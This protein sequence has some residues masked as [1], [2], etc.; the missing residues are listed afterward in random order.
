MSLNE[1]KP[2]L[3]IN[4]SPR[5]EQS[6]TLVLSRALVAGY[7]AQTG[8]PVDELTVYE[9]NIAPCRGCLT[10]WI[11]TPGKCVIRDDMDRAHELM[12]EAGL[13]V[14]SFPLY[15]FGMPSQL[16]AFLD[17]MVPVMRFYDGGPTVLRPHY[18]FDDKHFVVVSTCGF[19]ESGEIYDPLRSHIRTLFEGRAD[20]IAVP[21]GE[22]IQEPTMRDILNKRLEEL[23]EAGRALALEGRIPA[24][25]AER[26]S[27]PLINTRAFE[28]ILKAKSNAIEHT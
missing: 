16:K 2:V 12:R 11:Q 1:K 28:R 23:R 4:G 22:M 27:R 3:L 6:N 15:F 25:E 8:A 5:K 9:M 14:V 21:E 18:S 17:R 19:R 26:L 7:A 10:C 24:E 20:F 13:V